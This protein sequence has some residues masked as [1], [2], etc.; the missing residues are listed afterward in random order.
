[1]NVRGEQ[2]IGFYAKDNIP[3]QTELLFDYDYDN[4][5]S[6][7]FIVK[8]AANISWIKEGQAT[9]TST[10]SATNAKEPTGNRKSATTKSS[11]KGKK[12]SKKSDTK[13]KKG[14]TAGAKKKKASTTAAKK[15]L[16]ANG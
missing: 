2:R 7:K 8:P 5:Y 14:S 6:N 4:D 11:N 15:K 1:M 9:T 13:K 10:N 3:A 16:V 12:D